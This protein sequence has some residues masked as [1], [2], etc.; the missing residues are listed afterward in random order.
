MKQ[1][2]SLL[3]ALWVGLCF[4]VPTA[5]LPLSETAPPSVSAQGAILINATDRSVYFEKSADLPMGMA[6]TTKLMTALVV[7]ERTSPDDVVCISPEA[8]GI[9]GSSIYLIEGER[10]T[11]R[12]LLYALLLSSA[13]DAATA[14]AI[15]VA[16]DVAAF[17]DLMNQRAAELGLTQTHFTNPHGL[18]D[19]AH[20]TT[21]RELAAI[22]AEALAH[23]LLRQIVRTTRYTIP[24][25]GEPDQRLLLN[26]NKL[27]RDYDGAIGMKTGYTKKTGRTL[28]S[29]AERNGLTLIAVTLNAPD[30]WRDHRAMLDYG[31]SHYEAITLPVGAFSYSLPVTGGVSNSVTLVNAEPLILTLPRGHGEPCY[32]VTG[33]GRFLVAEVPSQ[34]TWGTVTL[35]CEGS[36]ATSPLITVHRVAP[37]TKARQSPLDRILNFFRP[38]PTE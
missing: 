19:E 13:N 1:W 22:A 33:T 36:E 38:E 35:R 18:Y 9:E 3:L 2:F 8:V 27:L 5:A 28:V 4:C 24:H 25:D 16:G 10:L 31:F 7:A 17:C 14:L 15:F 6:S 21:A 37:R 23:P 32:T 30:D 34:T 29:A 11:V 12:E 20:Y 26:H